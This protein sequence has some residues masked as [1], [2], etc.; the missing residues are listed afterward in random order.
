MAQSLKDFKGWELH[1]EETGGDSAPATPTR[2]TRRTRGA[3]LQISLSRIGDEITIK[4]GDFVL[5]QGNNGTILYLIKEIEHGVLRYLD[6]AAYRFI[7]A[8]EIDTLKLEDSI[9]KNEVY[10]TAYVES[11]KLCDIVEKASVLS[12]AEFKSEIVVDDSNSFNT[13]FCRKGCDIS[14]NHFSDELDF[15]EFY[16]LFQ[17]DK[18]HFNEELKRYTVK[19]AYKGT[20]NSSPSKQ[21]LPKKPKSSPKK[22]A[23][24]PTSPI[25]GIPSD[26]SDDDSA[27]SEGFESESSEAEQETID[28]EQSPTQPSKNARKRGR[29]PKDSSPKKQR[30]KSREYMNSVLLPLKKRL[31]LKKD[32]AP[33][34]QALSPSK[35]VQNTPQLFDTSTKAF[36][37]VKEKL[38]TSAKLASMPCREEEF[39]SIYL[40]L[41]SAIQERSGCCVYISGTPGV[42]KTA[43]IR[44]VISQLRELVTMNEL[45]DFDYIEINGLKLLNPNAAYEQLWEFVSGY[46]V[47]ATNSALLLENYF[48]EPNERKP[49]VVLMDELDQ[50]ATKKQNVMYN[51]FNWPTYQHSHLI[52]IAVAN[53]MDLPERLLSNKI[54]SRLGLRRIQ[55]VGYTFDQLGTI[56]RHRLDLLT[57]QNKRKVVVDSDAVGYA[58]R[59]VASV[60]GDARRALAICRRAVE[61]AEEEYLKNAP[62]TELN[63]LEVAEQTYR[64]QIDHISR[65]IN[66]TIN[67]PVAQFLSSLLFAA[68]LVLRAVIMRMQRSGAGEVSLGDVIDEMRNLLVMLT[69]K[70]KF[71]PI[72]SDN[73]GLVDF[74][75]GAETTE[76]NEGFRKPTNLRI[77]HFS[78]IISELTECGVLTEQSTQSERHRMIS[79]NVSEDEVKTAL[80]RDLEILA[81]K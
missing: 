19:A 35:K 46:K 80:D 60:S 37:D 13:F 2:R 1:F 63:E 50:L 70:H 62:A 17:T 40:N 66:E 8:L 15:R 26:V 27:A 29:K 24:E 11:I 72:I 3:S 74:F 16:K 57:K 56:I 55:F 30:D 38:H 73:G 53:T 22:S 7:K 43:T 34:M 77:S 14:G 64:V 45:S 67:S 42:G 23:V 21:S 33:N 6:V 52:V 49:L 61:I 58:S 54:S 76:P 44:E 12:Y 36:Q 25:A 69:G 71:D 48:S 47:S 18:A 9:T 20:P 5:V 81:I 68:K 4:A 65:A 32:N 41:E 51:F 78:Y 79:L 28:D 75:Y 31:K 39:A 59:K 10:I